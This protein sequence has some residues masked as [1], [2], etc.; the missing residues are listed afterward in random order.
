MAAL[1]VTYLPVAFD[2][3]VAIALTSGVPTWVASRGAKFLRRVSA[4][5][6]ALNCK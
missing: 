5:L 4:L 1:T 2:T 3:A 6:I